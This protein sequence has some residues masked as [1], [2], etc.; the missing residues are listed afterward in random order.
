MEE[1]RRGDS[2]GK[3]SGTMLYFSPLMHDDRLDWNDQSKY[4][5]AVIVEEIVLK[6]YV[7]RLV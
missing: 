4:H 7:S 1:T 3:A 6:P 2:G 5:I